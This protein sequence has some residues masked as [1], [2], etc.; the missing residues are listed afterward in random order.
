MHANVPVRHRM[1]SRPYVGSHPNFSERTT[2]AG[3]RHP[4]PV[5]FFKR[6]P[7]G[8]GV[9]DTDAASMPTPNASNSRSAMSALALLPTRTRRL[10]SSGARIGNDGLR[11]RCA[12]R[13]VVLGRGT[14]I[15]DSSRPPR[16]QPEGAIG[17]GAFVATVPRVRASGSVL[18]RRNV[19]AVTKVGLCRER[20]RSRLRAFR[21][22]PLRSSPRVGALAVSREMV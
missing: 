22:L 4:T 14:P 11:D 16:I 21:L 6:G 20:C 12:R 5:E 15:A 10:A 7:V 8:T 13:R 2:R 19:S 18:V 3:C 9:A 1:R 17:V